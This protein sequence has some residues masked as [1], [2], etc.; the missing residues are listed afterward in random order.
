MTILKFPT[1]E[2]DLNS[3]V[4][5]KEFIPSDDMKPIDNFN[6]K[7]LFTKDVIVDKESLQLLEN[8]IKSIFNYHKN[9][10]SLPTNLPQNIGFKFL[11]VNYFEQGT[12][13]LK[14]FIL[15]KNEAYG[16]IHLHDDKIDGPLIDISTE[17]VRNINLLTKNGKFL[18]ALK[19]NF[20][21]LSEKN[22]IITELVVLHEV[23][24]WLSYQVVKNTIISRCYRKYSKEINPPFKKEDINHFYNL[25]SNTLEG[26]SDSFSVFLTNQHYSNEDIISKYSQ[27]RKKT[28]ILSS[29]TIKHYDLN[30]IFNSISKIQQKHIDLLIDDFFNI[31][32]K[33]SINITKKLINKNPKFEQELKSQFEYYCKDLNIQF[34]PNKSL[35]ENIEE[36]LKKACLSNP[37]LNNQNQ[38]N[39]NLL[40]IRNNSLNNNSDNSNLKP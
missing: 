24:H 2:Y 8:T 28:S 27:S 17:H 16:K 32:I 21:N 25:V 23:G 9:N 29:N 34:N 19:N 38:I 20:S 30:D 40:Q 36:Q 13:L 33:N 22:S 3:K 35:I 4:N 1:S 31:A 18:K 6:Y 15:R 12:H 39:F 26:F 7:N 5:P 14:E 11:R 37:T 10:H